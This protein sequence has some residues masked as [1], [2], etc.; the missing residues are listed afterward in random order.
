LNFLKSNSGLVAF[1]EPGAVYCSQ[2][3]A[4]SSLLAASAAWETELAAM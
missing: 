4:A 1:A 2:P 3:S